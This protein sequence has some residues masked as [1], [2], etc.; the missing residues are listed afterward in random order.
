MERRD[1]HALIAHAVHAALEAHKE[2]LQLAE[3]DKDKYTGLAL[4]FRWRRMHRPQR[5]MQLHMRAA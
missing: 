1:V 5:P 3:H 2:Q 4:R